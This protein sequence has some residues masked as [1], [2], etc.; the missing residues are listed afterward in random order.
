MGIDPGLAN[1][2]W[3]VI[4]M[5]NVKEKWEAVQW[6][7]IR[8][9]PGTKKG[10][11][12][13]EI[14]E[15]LQEIIQK[16]QPNLVAIEEVFFGKNAKTA[17]MVGEARGVI[18]LAALNAKILIEEFTP[19]Q[20]KSAIVG[21]GRAEKTQIQKMVRQELNLP[22][23]PKPDDAADGLA[24]ALTAAVTSVLGNHDR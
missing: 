11:R 6:G 20:V 1:T 12:L 14:Y 22:E 9:R 7:V 19:L 24:A 15:E 3:G 18:I 21:Y 8:T 10:E 17:M 16:Y 5:S 2:G 4:K 13:K 23:I